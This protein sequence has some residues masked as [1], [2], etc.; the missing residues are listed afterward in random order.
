MT[1][2]QVRIFVS[3]PSDTQFERMRIDRV[4]E[5]LNGEFAEVARLSTIRWE[6]E[7]FKADSTFQQQI[8]EAAE[9]DIVIAILRH[10]LGTPLPED[11]ARMPNGQPYPSGTAYEILTAIDAG[12]K[13]GLP[14]VYVFRD[15]ESPT[16]SLDDS[17]TNAIVSE[18]WERLKTFF[19]TWFQ[20]PDGHFTAAFQQF[21]TT[22]EFEAQIDTLLRKWLADRILKGRPVI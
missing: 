21:H 15:P 18:Q 16:V 14:D 3:S 17:A 11:F 9:C 19:Q 4:I 20:T 22:D 7:F 13:T 8:P 6:R 10:R 5:R 12:R 2:R 1:I